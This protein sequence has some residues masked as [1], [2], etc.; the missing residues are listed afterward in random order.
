MYVLS[1]TDQIS[2]YT[3]DTAFDLSSGVTHKGDL[4]VGSQ[5]NQPFTMEFNSDGTKLFM[6]GYT[7]DDIHE[8]TLTTA[9][10]L[11]NTAPT[12]SSSS[13]SDGASS[14][15]VND[16]IVLTFSEVVDAESGNIIIKKSS[17]LIYIISKCLTFLI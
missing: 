15:G 10:E 2:E 11:N 3:L 13:P 8:Y 9:F 1:Y 12:L 7:N 6:Q 16:N 4:D 14:V 17:L 5:D